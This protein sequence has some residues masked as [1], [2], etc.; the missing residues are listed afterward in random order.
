[1]QFHYFSTIYLKQLGV[2]MSTLAK[3][4]GLTACYGDGKTSGGLKHSWNF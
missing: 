2:I 1:M 3:E 4:T